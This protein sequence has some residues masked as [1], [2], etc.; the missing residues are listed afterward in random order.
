MHQ[1]CFGTKE[2]EVR[3]DREG[4]SLVHGRPLSFAQSFNTPRRQRKSR[5]VEST[6][7]FF[8]SCSHEAERHCME[9]ERHDEEDCMAK[10]S[11]FLISPPFQ[12]C[13][14]RLLGAA[15][16][17]YFLSTHPAPAWTAAA[18]KH[19]GRVCCQ[20]LSTRALISPELLTEAFVE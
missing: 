19:G 6:L 10:K 8:R 16:T 17:F 3:R 4:I 11:A 12:S 14:S 9:G 15:V 5:R 2:S 18:C 1:P 20:L 13:L 7:S